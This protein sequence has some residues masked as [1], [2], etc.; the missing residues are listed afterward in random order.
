MDELDPRWI[1]ARC[2]MRSNRAEVREWCW[3]V[4]QPTRKTKI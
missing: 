2:T 3:R 1:N 4:R